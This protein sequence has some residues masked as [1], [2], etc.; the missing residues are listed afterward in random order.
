MNLPVPGKIIVLDGDVTDPRDMERILAAIEYEPR[1]SGARRLECRPS[2]WLFT[3]RTC[4]GRILK[5]RLPSICTEPS[6][7]CCLRYGI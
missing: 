2:T 3:A 4:T 6:T 1:A 7:V 5:R